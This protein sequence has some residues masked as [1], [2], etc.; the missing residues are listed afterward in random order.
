MYVQMQLAS[1]YSYHGTYYRN[2]YYLGWPNF[3]TFSL[4]EMHSI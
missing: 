3:P 4:A 1:K 2:Y